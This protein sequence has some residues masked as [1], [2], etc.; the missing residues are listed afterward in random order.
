VSEVFGFKLYVTHEVLWFLALFYA[1]IVFWLLWKFWRVL[2]KNLVVRIAAIVLSLALA[3]AVPLGDVLSTSFKMA[4]LCP[5]VGL[6]VKRP[7]VVDGFYSNVG[8]PDML[9]RGFKYIEASNPPAIN[10][11]TFAIG[12]I[13]LSSTK[14]VLIQLSSMREPMS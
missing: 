14:R 10:M 1:P 13:G 2:P 3:I 9:E 7:V 6:F 8:S 12:A 5:Q 4:E 11:S